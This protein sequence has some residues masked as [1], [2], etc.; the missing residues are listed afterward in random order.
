MRRDSSNKL[1]P[2]ECV[3]RI[4]KEPDKD[5][6]CSLC[7]GEGWMWDETL[8]THY[9]VV[10][11]IDASNALADEAKEPGLL[12]APLV[13][14]YI[15][16]SEEITQEDKVVE[17]VLDNEGNLEEPYQ[18]KGLYRV[19]TLWDYRSDRGRLEYWK[20]YTHLE[21]VKHLNAPTYGDL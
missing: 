17:L 15:R 8:I 11:G 5:T 7:F 6:F 12:N 16:Y 10:R 19:E 14:F 2:C 20:L 9:K 3:D 4:T 1:I 18:R 13:V 21:K